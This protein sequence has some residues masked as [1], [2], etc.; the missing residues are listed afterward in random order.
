MDASP[1]TTPVIQRRSDASTAHASLDDYVNSSTTQVSPDDD[2]AA[3][4][5]HGSPDDH[6]DSSTTHVSRDDHAATSTSAVDQ[7]LAQLKLGNVA[8]NSPARINIEDTVSIKVELSP[9]QSQAALLARVDEPGAKLSE[10]LQVSNL[11]EARLSGEGFK[12]VAVTPERQAV[13][14]GITEWIWDVTPET[15]GRRQL[16]LSIDALITVNGELVPRTLRTFRKPI[17][18]EVSSGQRIGGF[19]GE[20]G[21][22]AWTTLLVPLF[23]WVAKKRQAKAGQARTNGNAA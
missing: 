23:G 19:L 20:H 1:I 14:S 2:V 8:F 15:E 7:A 11:M 21:K 13:S 18:V 17:E 16:T 5:R 9:N 4:T 22:W 10:S 3:S 6:V 12:I